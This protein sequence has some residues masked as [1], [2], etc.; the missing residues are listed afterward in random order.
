[1]AKQPKSKRRILHKIKLTEISAVDRPCQEHAKMTIMKRASGPV[2]P[3][4][5]QDHGDLAKALQTATFEF[6]MQEAHTVIG[7]V[8]EESKDG[9]GH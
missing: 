9:G 5:D 3:I 8:W 4:E 2:Q 6:A 1:M 7:K